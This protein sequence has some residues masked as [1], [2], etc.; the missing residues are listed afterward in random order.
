MMK[1]RWDLVD[2][3]CPGTLHF[4]A[5]KNPDVDAVLLGISRVAFGH[6][7]CRR[8]ALVGIVFERGSGPVTLPGRIYSHQ[9]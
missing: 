8:T 2:S 7:S 6:S 9:T 4:P 5:F 3:D 1:I